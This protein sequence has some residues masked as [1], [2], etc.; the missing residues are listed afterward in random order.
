MRQSVL[1]FKWL[2]LS[3]ARHNLSCPCQLIKHLKVNLD[4]YSSSLFKALPTSAL[5]SLGINQHT[6]LKTEDAGETT[7]C[8]LVSDDDDGNN[9]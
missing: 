3:T 4:G 2:I 9:L 5:G 1:C 7:E 8:G 6:T